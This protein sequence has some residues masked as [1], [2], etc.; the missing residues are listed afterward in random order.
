MNMLSSGRILSG[1]L[2]EHPLI[3]S[4]HPI[5]RAQVL[6]PMLQSNLR[7]H[8]DV[9]RFSTET[10]LQKYNDA[11]KNALN[12]V[13]KGSKHSEIQVSCISFNK[14]NIVLIFE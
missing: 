14:T 13:F 8:H 12:G 3:Q 4:D 11:A 5:V 1:K 10:I 2:V 7:K 6:Y 9:S